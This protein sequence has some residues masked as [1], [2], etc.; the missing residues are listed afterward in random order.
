MVDERPRRRLARRATASCSARGRRRRGHARSVRD[1]HHGVR[2]VGQRQVDADDRP[3]RA[4]QRARLP[5][6]DPRSRGRLPSLDFAVVLGGAASR[7]ARR[8]GDRRAARLDAQRG[9]STCSASRSIIGPSS[10][11]SSCPRSPS[12]ARAP[13]ARTGSSSTRR[14]TCCRRP[15]SRRGARAAS[16]RHALRHRASRAASPQPVIDTINTLL[17]VGDHPD[18]TVEGVLQGRR[19]QEAAARRPSD[20]LAPGPRAVLATDSK[21]DAAIVETE[22]PQTERMRHSRK[23][24]EGNLGP[25][26]F[27]FRGPTSKLN[28]KA[29]NLHAVRPARR[30][31]RRRDVELP[32]AQR[33]VL[34]VVPRATSRIPSSPTRPRQIEHDIDARRRTRAAR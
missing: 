4:A 1:E 31:R 28:L 32:P 26:S 23:Y 9:R 19:R 20:K 13:A 3:A 34:A 16:A 10:S 33:R 2:H 18:K 8:G 15:G 27:V 7:A 11:R 25:H 5:V 29:H 21:R 30:R 17:V 14:I 6:R 12:C 24:V 22:K